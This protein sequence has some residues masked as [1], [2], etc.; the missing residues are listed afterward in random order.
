[1]P[2]NKKTI[3]FGKS[4]IINTWPKYRYFR[5]SFLGPPPRILPWST[6]PWP[7]VPP[8]PGS[9]GGGIR[10]TQKSN[11]PSESGQTTGGKLP[12]CIEVILR[13]NQINNPRRKSQATRRWANDSGGGGKVPTYSAPKP[14]PPPTEQP[15]WLPCPP[16]GSNSTPRGGGRF[17]PNPLPPSLWRNA[18]QRNRTRKEKA[19][20]SQRPLGQDT[21]AGRDPWQEG[22]P[23]GLLNGE[24]GAKAFRG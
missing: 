14:P 22:P 13:P 4:S 19:T 6:H 2:R 11:R 24:I 10:R 21:G 15:R 7:G 17:P 23:A 5:V 18:T 3:L 20:E 8:P 9:G 16:R 12:L 1:M